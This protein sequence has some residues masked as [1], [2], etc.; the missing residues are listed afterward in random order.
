M[1]DDFHYGGTELELFAQARNWKAYLRERITPHLGRNVLEVGAGIGGTT[2]SLA[3]GHVGAWTCLEPDPDLAKQLV[4]SLAKWS[5][6]PTCNTRVVVGS[7]DKLDPRE[8]FDTILYIDVLEHIP[9]DREEVLRASARLMCGGRLVVLA[10]A[11]NWLYAP[12]DRAIGH[13]RRYNSHTLA[14]CAPP[15]LELILMHYLDSFGLWASA[16]NRFLMRSAMPTLGQIAFWDRCLVPLSRRADP[17]FSHHFGK[18]LL[19]VWRSG[20]VGECRSEA[21]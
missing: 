12:F 11:H 10:P 7:I 18:S 19:A 8:R 9:D 15:G 3:A 6:P 20:A 21:G 17:I 14:A 4:A 2:R 16:M 1:G 13:F 5:H